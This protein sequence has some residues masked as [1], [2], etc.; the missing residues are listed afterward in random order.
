MKLPIFSLNV[1]NGLH[2]DFFFFYRISLWDNEKERL[3]LL[4]TQELITVKY[5]F[6]ALKRLEFQ[7]VSLD[8]VDTLIIGDLVYPSGSLVP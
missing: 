8:L 2:S 5:D 6:I 4:T 7:K 1:N 3:I